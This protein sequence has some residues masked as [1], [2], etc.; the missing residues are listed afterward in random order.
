M[1]ESDMQDQRAPMAAQTATP[2]LSSDSAL[3]LERFRFVLDASDDALITKALDGTI[4]TWNRGAERMFGYTAGEAIGQSVL[5]L[6]PAE[7]RHEEHQI[8]DRLRAGERIDPFDTVRRHKDGRLIHV[9]ITISP[10]QNEAGQIV[11]AAKI[12]RDI[13]ERKHTDAQ[14]ALAA[15]LIESSDDAIISKTLDG[16]ITSWNKGAERV[17]GYTAE[18]AIGQPMLM[19]FPQY[20]IDEEDDILRRIRNGERIEHFETLRVRKDRRLIHISAT[21]SPLRDEH[22]RIVGASKIARDISARKQADAQNALAALLI[23]S[24]DD[25]IISKTLDGIITSWNTGAQRVFG[26]TAEEAIGQPM[27]MLF[28][29]EKAHEEDFI[30]GQI[31]AGKRVDHFETVRI[32]RDKT[33][34]HVSVTISPVHDEHGRIVGA[35]KIAR[36]I[37]QRRRA[38]AHMRL[39]STVFD[40][41]HEGVAIADF[42]G[43]ILQINEA[44]TQITGYDRREA[45]GRTGEMFTTGP[46]LERLKTNI[47]QALQTEGC[48]SGE[49]QGRRRSGQN[50]AGLLT[51]SSVPSDDMSVGRYVALI[52]DITQLR[53]Q[54]E[55][56][57][58]M[59]H[60]DALT[61]LPNRALLHDRLEQGIARCDRDDTSLALLYM[62]LDGFKAVNDNHGHKAGDEVLKAVSNRVKA[63]LRR[64]DTLARLGG[65]E[66]VAVMPG[67]SDLDQCI[68]LIERI[69]E[70]CARPV[71]FQG[72][73]LKV[74]T[75]VGMTTY[76]NDNVDG[77]H[78]IR[79]ADKAMYEAK[80]AGKNGYAI[81]DATTS[82]NFTGAFA[83][84]G[85]LQD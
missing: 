76:P 63:V 23:E 55:A 4:T 27:L 66:F 46:Q 73:E 37:T 7:R 35:S 40:H 33:P 24:S 31:R 13:S 75:S 2:A 6:Y 83:D 18:E 29:Q 45:I 70:E 28:P 53:E 44:F 58:R 57:K 10:M 67:L 77:E 34:I 64:T 51:I 68:H 25:A 15:L 62:D 17:F 42:S 84:P 21:I 9:S 1:N 36:D 50:Y 85:F 80:H 49:V 74:S 82:T 48:W 72:V 81:F 71:S 61:G 52:S 12:A 54:R 14:K 16:I 56:L 11:G 47:L 3:E 69:I 20:K 26:Y 8:V 59:A 39:A 19:L 32:R 30:L 79:H 43:R 60:F 22:G 5:M 65:D 78:L 38:E 41:T